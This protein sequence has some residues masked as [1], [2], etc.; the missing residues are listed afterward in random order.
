MTPEQQQEFDHC[1]QRLAQLLHQ[2][3]QEQGLPMKTLAEIETTVRHQIQTQVS[4]Q[5]GIFL[6][7]RR[8]PPKPGTTNVN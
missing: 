3:A 8:V 7:T 5:L 4:P 1:V 6:S 2:D